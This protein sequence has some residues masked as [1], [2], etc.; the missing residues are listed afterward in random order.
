M[1]TTLLTFLLTSFTICILN[2]IQETFEDCTLNFLLGQNDELLT[3]SYQLVKNVL[4]IHI[5]AHT[6][7]QQSSWYEGFQSFKKLF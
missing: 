5:H 7:T 3:T 4:D 2:K 6:H 1:Q